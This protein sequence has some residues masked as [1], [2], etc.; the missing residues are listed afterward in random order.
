LR[1]TVEQAVQ[2]RAMNYGTKRGLAIACCPGG[3]WRNF[4]ETK[5]SYKEDSVELDSGRT[6]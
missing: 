2:Y 4:E 5:K 6:L 1:Q 3:T